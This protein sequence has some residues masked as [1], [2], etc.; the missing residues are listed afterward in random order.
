MK[1]SV[2]AHDTRSKRP[3]L[4]AFLQTAKPIVLGFVIAA[5]ITGM[6][7]A[8]DGEDSPKDSKPSENQPATPGVEPSISIVRPVSW[9][10]IPRPARNA[11]KDLAKSRDASVTRCVAIE[12]ANSVTY[13]FHG[14]KR[15]GLFRK[16]DFVLTSTTEPIA[17]AKKR[18]DEQTLKR[19]WERFRDTIA[20]RPK[21]ENATRTGF[22]APNSH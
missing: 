18:Q 4:T 22:L 19:R 17:M 1:R 14:S 11:V 8:D 2:P 10:S 12:S 20:P 6:T 16:T 3:Y 7:R 13:E 5:S 21:A 15:L 9:W